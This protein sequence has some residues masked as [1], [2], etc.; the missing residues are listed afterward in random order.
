[1]KRLI[2][3]HLERWKTDKYRKPLLLRGARQVG[4]TYSVRELGKSFPNFIELNFEN[5]P[6]LAALF[7]ED[8]NPKRIIRDLEA[9]LVDQ[10]IIPGKTL[11]FFDEIQI[12]PQAITALRYFYEEMPELHVIAAGSLLNFAIELVGVPVGR[13]SFLNM[14]PLSFIEFLQACGHAFLIKEIIEHQGFEPISDVIHEKLLSLLSHYLAIGGM[15]QV[16]DAWRTENDP[17]LV[18]TFHQGL[19]S[20]YRQDFYKYAKNLNIKYLDALLSSLPYQLGRKFKYSAIE[21]EFKT[22]ELSPGLNLLCTA[23]IVHKILYSAAQGIP[24]GAQIDPND[25]KA[26]CLDVGLSQAILGLTLGEWLVN[27]EKAF[28][29]KGEIVEAFVGQELLAYT[30]PV[31]DAQ[32]YYWHRHKVGGEAEIDYVL[33]I[34]ENVVPIEVKSGAGSTLKSM[35]VFLEQHPHSPYGVRFST[36]NYSL[37][38]KVHSYPL[39][40]VAALFVHD[41]E[42]RK[43]FEYLFSK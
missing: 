12:A 30:D 35:H 23:D 25:F 28:I 2:D 16:V 8:L 5:Q 22:R 21:G 39:Y 7:Q 37:Y 6:Q 42:R 31:Y 38:E 33:Q 41:V 32:L 36:Q 17:R 1:M 14:Y 20:S 29:N 4:K 13:V 43:A 10:A 9:T 34:D 18:A 26:L 3:F 24:L 40:A 11:L 15:P 19:I 27:K